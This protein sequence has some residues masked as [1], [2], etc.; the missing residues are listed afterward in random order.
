MPKIILKFN[1][2]EEQEDFENTINGS[3]WKSAMWNLDK[4]LRSVVKYNNSIIDLQKLAT[5]EEIEVA[6][7]LREL[8]RELLDEYNLKLD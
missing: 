1:L 5:N 4:K 2:P 6:D 8:I 3:K 7:K